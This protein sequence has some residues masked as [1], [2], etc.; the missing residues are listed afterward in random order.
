M[1]KK[2]FI[3]M[4]E[5]EIAWN[6]AMKFDKNIRNLVKTLNN[7]LVIE[8]FDKYFADYNNKSDI[9]LNDIRDQFIEINK[10]FYNRN[11]VKGCR[12]TKGFMEDCL[13]FICQNYDYSAINI[14]SGNNPRD[15]R[16]YLITN[17]KN[18]FSIL[19]EE[20]SK[21]NDFLTQIYNYI[22]KI[23]HH[24][25]IKVLTKNI[26]QNK[27]I[28]NIQYSY[29]S[30]TSFIIF[31]LFDFLY[32]KKNKKIDDNLLFIIKTITTLNSILT[33]SFIYNYNEEDYLNLITTSKL[34]NPTD[35]KYL[36]DLSEWN[37]K[38]TSN[39]S[40]H[41]S[42]EDK[43]FI[44]QLFKDFDKELISRGYITSKNEG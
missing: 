6:S 40:A 41:F 31:L 33:I 4:F 30:I 9:D 2:E 34:N 35:E 26:E 16:T 42:K 8:I 10:L 7:I 20:I 23:D 3:K 18:I 17:N 11:L 21:E 24:T 15:F 28:R 27:K 43:E 22:A 19:N 37:K 44:N 36:N 13:S 32:T 38:V 12:Q 29:C 25:S 39:N 1:K 5:N 14:N